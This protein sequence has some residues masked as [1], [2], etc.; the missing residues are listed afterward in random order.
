MP[1]KRSVVFVMADGPTEVRGDHFKDGVGGTSS[2]LILMAETL[3]DH[4]W[5]VTVSSAIDSSLTHRGV[6][7]IPHAEVGTVE[8]TVL[9][10]V[11]GWNDRVAHLE[12]QSRIFFYFDTRLGG[13]P[14]TARCV[15][16]A[17][18]TFV[19]SEFSLDRLR[20]GLTT[21]L[22]A[23]LRVMRLPVEYLNVRASGSNIV[24]YNGLQ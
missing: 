21:P 13:T 19:N 15:S 8:S 10:L 17:G 5:R 23:R 11:N 3:A 16:W 1:Q 4:G 6:S 7:Y 9:A 2:A 22:V 14:D 20:P 18:L 24:Q 12:A